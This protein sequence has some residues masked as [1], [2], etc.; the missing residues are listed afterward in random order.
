M[1]SFGFE[2]ALHRLSQDN[3]ERPIGLLIPDAIGKIS[4]EQDLVEQT[5]GIQITP[6]ETLSFRF[7]TLSI[8]LEIKGSGPIPHFMSVL[9]PGR[10]NTTWL[11][12]RNLTKDGK[13]HPYFYPSLLLATALQ[14][15]EKHL[16]RPLD[17]LRGDWDETSIN[18]AVY[19]AVRETHPQPDSRLAK[20]IAAFS[21]WTGQEAYKHGFRKVWIEEDRHGIYPHFLRPNAPFNWKRIF[22]D[23]TIYTEADMAL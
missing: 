13:K 20:T 4:L 16:G 17:E 22:G 5:G 9:E 1:I 23:E 10:I 14:C 21:T 3:P 12:V 6:T 11:S 18:H 15:H 7:T 19:N 2:E 8:D